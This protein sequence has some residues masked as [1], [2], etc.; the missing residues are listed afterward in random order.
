MSPPRRATLR[1]L[2]TVL[3]RWWKLH[4]RKHQVQRISLAAAHGSA[5][6][7]LSQGRRMQMLQA[8]HALQTRWVQAALVNNLREGHTQY[9]AALTVQEK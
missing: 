7:G 2:Q 5:A 9:W 6:H 4:P 1:R 8:H 3:F